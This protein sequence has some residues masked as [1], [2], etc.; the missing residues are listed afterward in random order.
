MT[1]SIAAHEARIRSAYYGQNE[2][3][4]AL[5]RAAPTAADVVK[6][7]RAAISTRLATGP[8]HVRDLARLTGRT[9][10]SLLPILAAMEADGLVTRQVKG[11]IVTWHAVVAV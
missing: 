10:G 3:P 4:G 7:N 8:S 11:R 9:D 5:P 1:P 2:R 6:R